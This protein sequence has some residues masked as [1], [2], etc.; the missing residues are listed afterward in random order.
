[1]APWRRHTFLTRERVYLPAHFHHQRRMSRQQRWNDRSEG[2]AK[3]QA[4][5]PLTHCLTY[6]A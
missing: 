3:T 5:K 6:S 4:A 1:M 2:M